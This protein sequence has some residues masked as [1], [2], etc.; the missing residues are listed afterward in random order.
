MSN[1]TTLTAEDYEP[2][3]I[4]DK[5][6]TPM[7][8][9]TEYARIDRDLYDRLNN[10]FIDRIIELV[11][12]NDWKSFL[13]PDPYVEG[14]FNPVVIPMLEAMPGFP[15]DRS[16]ILQ[17]GLPELIRKPDTYGPV[18]VRYL[19]NLEM[20]GR[21]NDTIANFDDSRE[22]DPRIWAKTGIELVEAYWFCGERPGM[23]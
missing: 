15:S 14:S 12:D 7:P 22:Y 10:I 16:F 1:E 19:I 21:V 23:T 6:Y 17:I 11:Q 9:Y 18:P 4:T 8:G 20:D 2:V 3:I 5:D 13:Y